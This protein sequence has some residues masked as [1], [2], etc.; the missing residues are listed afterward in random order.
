MSKKAKECK[1]N[2]FFLIFI[3]ICFLS[4]RELSVGWGASTS[5]LGPKLEASPQLSPGLM[6]GGEGVVCF[7]GPSG[8]LLG[9]LGILRVTYINRKSESF[10]T[11]DPPVPIFLKHLLQLL[12]PPT[13][14]GNNIIQKLISYL[15]GAVA[16]LFFL[17]SGVLAGNIPF[18]GLF[19]EPG[20]RPRRFFNAAAAAAL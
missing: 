10:K 9:A 1:K 2:I 15:M 13:P 14:A 7:K 11:S 6:R 20:G 5:S 17:M 3:L 19:L 18:L 16:Y 8:A 12:P 4:R